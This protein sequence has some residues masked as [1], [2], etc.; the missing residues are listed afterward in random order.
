MSEFYLDD[1]K[2]Y[3]RVQHDIDDKYIETLII[4]SKNYIKEQ[5]GV[6]YHKCDTVYQ[7]AIMLMVAH[8]YDNRASISEKNLVNVPYTLD[9]LI[10]HIGVRG[11]YKH[12]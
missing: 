11:E 10:K 5:T 6:E 3:L 2:K 9:C 1:V 12:E 7:H 8:F 4:L